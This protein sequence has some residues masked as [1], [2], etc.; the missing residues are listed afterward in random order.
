M[1]FIMKAYM[2]VGNNHGKMIYLR[3]QGGQSFIYLIIWGGLDYLD[4][5]PIIVLSF[6]LTQP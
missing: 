5:R 4:A 1:Q 2:S 6:V 3:L